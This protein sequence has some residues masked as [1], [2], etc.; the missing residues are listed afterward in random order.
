M[1][2]ATKRWII[3][4]FSLFFMFVFGRIIPP[5]GPVTVA[6]VQVIGIFIGALVLM[7]SG[8]GMLLPG[9][10]A[11]VAM[12][13]SDYSTTAKLVSGLLGNS[14]ALM[15]VAVLPVAY[16]L[17]SSGT[18]LVL[19][20]KLMTSR[21]ARSSPTLFTGCILLGFLLTG[22]F[23]SPTA[24]IMMGFPLLDNITDVM[25]Y[26]RDDQYPRFLTLGAYITI[27]VANAVLPHKIII[28]S[29]VAAFNVGMAAITGY[30]WSYGTHVL[31]ALIALLIILVVYPLGMKFL[32]RVDFSK[33]KNFDPTKVEGMSKEDCT[34]TKTQR[35][36]LS[37][38]GVGILYPLLSIFLPAEWAFT[39]F[40]NDISLPVWFFAILIVLTL[41]RVDGKKIAD[42]EG[43]FKNGVIWNL[44]IGVTAISLLGGGLSSSDAG[45]QTWLVEILGPVFGEMSWPMFVLVGVFASTLLTNFISDTV[46]G[47]LVATF[48]A[49]FAGSFVTQG[50]NVGVMTAAI[51]IGASTAY[52]TGASYVAAPLLLGRESMPAK[53]MWTKGLYPIFLY[54]I[55]TAVV[56]ILSGYIF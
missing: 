37:A 53:W 20:K 24:G 46:A 26:K 13:V 22:Q 45:I 55:I 12:V 14:T 1:S 23:L 15:M 11:F 30:T 54:V 52:L 25:G 38:F 18:G 50:I 47:V 39:T 43:A 31:V 10:L 41:V 40:W 9:L 21:I 35:V 7:V 48:L 28:V 19:A 49:V 6:G 16:C 51:S 36:C 17:T 27:V 33:F 29:I 42:L 4:I 56:T 44:V 8:F 3:L 2:E 5:W 32:F 34:F